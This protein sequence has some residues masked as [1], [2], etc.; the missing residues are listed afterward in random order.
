M[1]T[2]ALVLVSALGIALFS[3][4]AYAIPPPGAAQQGP[5]STSPS[6]NEACQGIQQ[7]GGTGCGPAATNSV[8]NLM[9]R[10]L[11]LLSL[12]AG[13]IVVV[14]VILSGIKFVTAN[15]D[16]QQITS[17]RQS[18]IYALIGIVIVA[19]AQVLVHFVIGKTT[20]GT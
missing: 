3:A 10:A 5:Q 18:L 12:I 4:P 7:L 13:F 17:A 6:T 8:S 19:F 14:M 15:G 16:S 1:V 2:A 9:K 20:K 11:E